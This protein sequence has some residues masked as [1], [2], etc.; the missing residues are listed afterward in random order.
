M[1][2]EE[3]RAVEECPYLTIITA[4]TCSS[5]YLWVSLALERGMSLFFI[6][7]ILNRI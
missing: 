5:C 2:G 7:F 4:S 3:R 1:R 6:L